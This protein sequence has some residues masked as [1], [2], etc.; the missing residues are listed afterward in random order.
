GTPLPTGSDVHAVMLSK[1]TAGFKR[2]QLQSLTSYAFENRQPVT[3]KFLRQRKKDLIEAGSGGLLEFV[4]SRFD[5]STVA[6]HEPAK[7]KL[8]DAA[9]AL[10]SGRT[11]VLPMGYVICGPVGTGKTFLITCFA[12]EVGIP[13]VTLKNFRSMW[14]G[15]T[16]GNLER[17]L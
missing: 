13:S 3:M 15:V 11:D 10:R 8:R 6:G 1:L 17:V 16:E 12:G 5:L 4:Q 9:A 7:K 14:Q 2:V